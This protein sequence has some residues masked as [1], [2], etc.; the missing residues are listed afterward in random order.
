V[1][2]QNGKKVVAHVEVPLGIR[3]VVHRRSSSDVAI[4]HLFCTFVT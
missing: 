4:D 2:G 3:V 1:H